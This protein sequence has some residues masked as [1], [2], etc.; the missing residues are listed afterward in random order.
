MHRVFLTHATFRAQIDGVDGTLS[1][2]Q[3]MPQTRHYVNLSLVFV[4]FI[5]LFKDHAEFTKTCDI[6]AGNH[7]ELSYFQEN[8][9]GRVP[10]SQHALIS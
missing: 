3:M 5:F 10:S 7:L 6:S 8:G 4:N 2:T 1:V 9:L